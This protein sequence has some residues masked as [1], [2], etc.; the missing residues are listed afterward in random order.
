MESL[1]AL[2]YLPTTQQ[3]ADVLTKVIPSTKL[4]PLLTKHGMIDTTPSLRGDDEHIGL[5]NTP[6]NVAQ[7]IQHVF[8]PTI[9]ILKE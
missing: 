7:Y 3:L 5:I 4:Q 2:Q 9:H 1:I 8:S 6:T